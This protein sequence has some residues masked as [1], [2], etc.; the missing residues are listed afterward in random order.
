M[1]AADEHVAAEADAIAMKLTTFMIEGF[2]AKE[3]RQPTTDEIAQLFDELTPDRIAE[4]LGEE[5][6]SSHGEEEKEEEGGEDEEEEEEG[7]DEAEVD[8]VVEEAEKDVNAKVD[9]KTD[10]VDEEQQ[11]EN[12]K[13]NFKNADESDVPQLDD[14]RVRVE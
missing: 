9:E 14:K 12:N 6:T 3:G 8:E 4:M 5:S 13:R 7:E 11:K 10:A 2:V 1:D